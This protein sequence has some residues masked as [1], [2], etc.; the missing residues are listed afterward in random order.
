LKYSPLVERVSGEGADAWLTHYEAVGARERGEDVIVLSVGDPDLDTPPTVVERAIAQLRAGD[1]HYVAAA[2][3]PALREAIARR[4]GERTGQ[5]VDPRDVVCFAGAQNAL[6]ALSLCLAG[7]GDEVVTFD[8]MYP[9]YPATIE[10]GGARLVRVPSG[11]D[12]RPDVDAL[13][14]AVGS[15]TRA[16]FW[17]TPNNPSGVVLSASELDRIAEIA[18]RHELWLVSDEVYA[19]LAAGGRVPSL[20]ARLPEQVVTVS[21]LSKTHAMT[22][23]RAGWLVGPRT[24]A[25]HAESLAMCMLFGLPGFVQEAAIEALAI[26]PEA[27][28]RMRDYLST[29][30]QQFAAGLQ[31]APR[32]RTI[33]PEAGMFMLLDVSETGLSGYEFMRRLYESEKV[34]VMDGA[35]FGAQTAGYV[36]VCFAT[37][38]PVLAEAC[39]RIRRFCNNARTTARQSASAR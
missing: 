28:R 15:R 39:A 25:R 11:P 4:H 19:G 27:E 13:G 35:A 14:A 30:C 7:P 10:V 26:A 12:L 18:R 9:T 29:R 24:L 23:W 31:G 32:I 2:G 33:A 16:I 8:P 38:E 3:R 22:G 17:A 21:S 5:S 34:A 37:E 6:F 20:A 1:T 36:R